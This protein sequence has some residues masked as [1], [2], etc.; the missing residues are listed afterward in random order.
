MRKNFGVSALPPAQPIPRGYWLR[1]DW[2][3]TLARSVV[4]GVEDLA[5]IDPVVVNQFDGR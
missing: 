3:E 5:L 1:S 2:P 4:F